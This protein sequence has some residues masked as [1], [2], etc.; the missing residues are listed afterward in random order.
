MSDLKVTREG[1]GVVEAARVVASA[2]LAGRGGRL[3]VVD[4]ADAATVAVCD[5][6]DRGH[7]EEA[8]ALALELR[9]AQGSRLAWPA[10]GAR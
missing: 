6:H 1:M 7:V 4:A 2:W 3:R 5:L 10:R 9:R 8:A